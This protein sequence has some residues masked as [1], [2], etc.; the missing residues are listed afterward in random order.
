MAGLYDE[1]LT[2]ARISKRLLHPG[3]ETG[4]IIDF[5]ISMIRCLRV[6]D[7]QGV[8]L[9]RVADP[10]RSYLRYTRFIYMLCCTSNYPIVSVQIQFGTS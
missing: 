6:I 5:Y 4:D 10:I 9:Y 1:L 7:P 8:L 3:A 2:A